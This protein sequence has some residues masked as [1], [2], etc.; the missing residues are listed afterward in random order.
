V[1]DHEQARLVY[2][3]VEIW[4]PSRT[5]VPSDRL[6]DGMIACDRDFVESAYGISDL[7]YRRMPPRKNG[8][9]AFTHATNV[10]MYLKLAQ[11]QPHLV[12]AGLLHDVLED[13]IDLERREGAPLDLDQVL[14]GVRADF[15]TAVV[16]VSE[17]CGFPRDVAERVVDVVW[18]LTRHKADMYYKSISG[19]FNH[20][21]VTV[22]VGAALVKLADRMHNI[23]TIEN[24]QD[25]EKLYQ[26]FKNLF[27]L[28]NA[29]QLRNEIRSRRTDPRL[30]VSLD[31]MFKKC[32][33]ATFQALLRVD[34]EARG[35]DPIFD[36]VTYLAL[37]LR[38]FVHEIDGLWKVRHAELHAGAPVW[39]LY[40]G[41]VEKYD[42]LL[43]HEEAKYRDHVQAELA[44]VAA[45]F[46]PLHLT[47]LDLHRAIAF[48]DAMALAEVVASLL[49]REEYVIRGFE[50]GRL[51][52][53][54][55]DCMK[56][57][58]AG[59]AAF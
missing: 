56:R 28:N 32:G 34:H 5:P 17:A 45:T 23:Q 46:E 7:L 51:C 54:G 2:D 40:N 47:D 55:K 11:S 18:T 14:M 57:D 58:R 43:H 21:D 29:K 6:V 25:T 24:Y 37:A 38:K 42:H 3:D 16:T 4:S 9:P 30:L 50:C 10:A 36:L 1:G 49:Y 52:R 59:V 19:I 31:K 22:R 12:A 20:F 48:K 13:H 8:E 39:N 15:A 26:C 53:R 41:I 44:F 35:A 33:K 27:I